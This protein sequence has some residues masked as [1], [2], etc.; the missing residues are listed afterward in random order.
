MN[1][2]QSIFHRGDGMA[3]EQAERLTA[4][5]SDRQAAAQ[6][7]GEAANKATGSPGANEPRQPETKGPDKSTEGFYRD[8]F[9]RLRRNPFAIVAFIIILCLVLAAIFAPLL[10]PYGYAEQSLKDKWAPCSGTHFFGTDNLGRDIFTRILY[11]ARVSLSV[12]L[13]AE[14]I[15]TTIGVLMG[16]TA[17]YYG[18]KIDAIISRIIE[19]FASF[20][21]MLFAI[22]MT[23]VLG[24]GVINCFIA[25]GLIG[26]TGMARLIRGEVLRLKNMEFVEAAKA[27]GSSGFRIITK[28]LV[29]NC[30]P[31]IIVIL[32]MDIPGDIL[33]ESTLSFLGLGV[34][35]PTPS[36]G[37]MISAAQLYLRQHPGYSI[38]P[39]LAI[40]ITI[41]AFNILG[42]CLRDAMDPKLRR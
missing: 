29:P 21:F 25:I 23:C 3:A 4:E 2:F 18:G 42:D 9:R 12:G 16:A 1:A 14:M 28:Q 22:T 27:N 41:L 39:G 37:E 26:W 7:A 31:T 34:Q 33:L 35:P 6:N 17:G 40:F 11:G 38:F 5:Q 8:A 19:V 10:T 13:I 15:A 32:T 24:T 30:L 36:W 20:P